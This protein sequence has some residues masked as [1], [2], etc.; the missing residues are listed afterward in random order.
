VRVLAT[1][2]A[3]L[4]LA[5]PAQAKL[6][7]DRIA[8]WDRIANCETGGNWRMSGSTYEG[9]VGFAG[10]TWRWWA[11]E[12]GLLARYPH[13]NLAPRLVQIRVAEYG[14]TRYRGYWGCNR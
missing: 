4:A 13:A 7:P 9:G 8:F 11:R 1:A 10:T 5:A 6:S 12:L 3:I 2:T 14:L